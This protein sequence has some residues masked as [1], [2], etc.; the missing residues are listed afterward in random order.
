M[1]TRSDCAQ[2]AD[3]S[4]VRSS[5]AENLN[6]AHSRL[7]LVSGISEARPMRRGNLEEKHGRPTISTAAFLIGS[8]FCTS[9]QPERQRQ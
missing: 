5:Q 8:A 6:Q 3:R 7:P 2:V 1:A 9:G 4:N